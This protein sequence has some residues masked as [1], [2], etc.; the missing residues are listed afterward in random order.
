MIGLGSSTFTKTQEIL[1]KSLD[2]NALRWDVLS[3]N[4]AN[5]NTPNFKR[6][7]VTFASQMKRALDSET[8]LSA[9]KANKTSSKHFS[10]HKSLNYKDVEAKIKTEFNTSLGN[11][12]NNVDR[13]FESGEALKTSLMYNA[14][15]TL[16]QRNYTLVNDM[17]K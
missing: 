11:N 8:H 3:N 4:I 12:N 17:L 6:S 15:T 2:A 10:F 9:F 7:D 13:S 14:T 16:L 1:S 5:A